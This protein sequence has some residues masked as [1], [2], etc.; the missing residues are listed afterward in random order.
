MSPSRIPCG[1]GLDSVLKHCSIA[2]AQDRC[3]RNPL[4][5]VVS[6][7]FHHGVE[8]QQMPCLLGSIFHSGNSEWAHRFAVRFRDVNPSKRLK[9]IASTLEFM[10]GPCLLFWCVPDFLVHPRGFFAIVFRHSSNGENLAAVRV[11]QQVLQGSHL[12]PSTSLRRL[13]TKWP[14]SSRCSSV[15]V[16]RK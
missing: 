8:C 3:W 6:S 13:R 7:G 12:A 14:N 11:G 9:L 1:F 16:V 5:V 10:Y 2:S 4:G 15:I